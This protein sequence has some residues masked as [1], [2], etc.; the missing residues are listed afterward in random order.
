MDPVAASP[1]VLVTGGSGALGEAICRRLARPPAAVA[2][3]FHRHPPA[4]RQV[5]RAIEAAGGRARAYE[6]D[7]RSDCAAA[8]L[9]DGVVADFGRLDVLVNAAG[10]IRDR[11]LLEMTDDDVDAVLSLNLRGAMVVT[12]AAVRHMLAARRGAI[13]NISSAAASRPGTGQA[14]YVASK[15]GL[16]G[17][18]R[19]MA[20]ELASRGIRVNGVAPGVIDSEMTRDVRQRNGPRLLDRVLLRRF[21]TPDEVAAA[22]SFLASADASY[23]TGQ[24]LHVDGGRQ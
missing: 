3:H 5:V 14:N 18:T 22:V 20:V 10:V 15:A 11:L 12:R 19:A 16:E 6:A 23:I 17:F 24:V 4:A 9:V 1:V 21:G 2:V 8:A 7:L 13:V